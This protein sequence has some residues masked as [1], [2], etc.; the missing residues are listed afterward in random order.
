MTHLKALV[1][2]SMVLPLLLPQYAASQESAAAK[3]PN[4]SE[5][6]GTNRTI[7]SD[8]TELF[9]TINPSFIV[10]QSVR[11][12]AHLSKLGDRFLPYADAAVTATLTVGGVSDKT[13]TEKPD[14][15]GVFRMALIPTK[16]GT[17]TLVIEIAGRDGS[18]RLVLEKIPVYTDRADAVAHQGPDTNAGAIKY[19]K[20]ESWD[21]NVY[22]SAPVAR[23]ALDNGSTARRVLAVPRTAIV[24]VDGTPHVY[25]QRHPEAFDLKRVN[26]GKSNNTYVEIT[27]GLREGQRIVIRGGNKMPRK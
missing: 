26:T 7:F 2:A 4:A 16:A 19:S 10:G 23:V 18:D 6:R 9:I 25:L 27:E 17:G 24:D 21:E 22:A 13:S 1:I 12:G 8:K 20:E 11:L 5:L 14:R 3:V 15:P